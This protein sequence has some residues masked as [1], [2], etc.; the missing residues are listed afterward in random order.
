MEL[1]SK[2][3]T[4]HE[5]ICNSTM[6]SRVHW[7]NIAAYC[8]VLAYHTTYMTW[9]SWPASCFPRTHLELTIFINLL[10]S[11]TTTHSHSQLLVL[12]QAFLSPLGASRRVARNST[13][14]TFH[15]NFMIMC[16]DV[17]SGEH[18]NSISCAFVTKNTTLEL[19]LNL[20]LTLTITTGINEYF[21]RKHNH[22]L[23]FY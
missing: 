13:L 11:M 19:I 7:W 8:C 6:L 21:L 1:R 9:L 15:T 14:R 18:K 10:E 23:H 12:H 4:K 2:N 20:T 22:K 3:I 16:G 5:P 17:L